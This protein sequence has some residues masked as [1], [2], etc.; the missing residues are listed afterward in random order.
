M[1]VSM[2]T[3]AGLVTSATAATVATAIPGST[4]AQ[5]TALANLLTVLAKRK[6]ILNPLLGLTGTGKTEFTIG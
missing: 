1:A 2:T 5:I 4:A 3:F 6:D